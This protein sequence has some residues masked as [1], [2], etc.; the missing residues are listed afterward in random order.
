MAKK[1]EKSEKAVEKKSKGKKY[2]L[3]D[4]I[5]ERSDVKTVRGFFDD[6]EKMLYDNKLTPGDK[7][8]TPMGTLIVVQRKPRNAR[9]PHSGESIKVP[10]RLAVRFKLANSYRVW[11][12]KKAE[13]K[14]K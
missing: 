10:S 9:N 5:E 4:I 7:V 3:Q 11:G 14:K 6:V 1:S 13:K 2:L 12:K 8:S